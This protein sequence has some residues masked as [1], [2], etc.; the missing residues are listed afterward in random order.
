MREHAQG[1]G[2]DI[3]ELPGRPDD[4]ENLPPFALALLP[5]IVVIVTNFVFIQIVVPLIDTS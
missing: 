5:V 1:E 2:F 3:G 4:D